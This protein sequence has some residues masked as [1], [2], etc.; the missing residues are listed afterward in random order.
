[1]SRK[2][3]WLF[4]IGI[5]ASLTA[6]DGGNQAE[7]RDWMQTSAKNLRGKIPP[8]PQVSSYTPVNYDAAGLPDPFSAGK[9]EMGRERGGGGLRPDFNRPKE[10]LESY[11]LDS[12]KYVGYLH[13][14]RV[15]YGMV[16]ADGTLFQV[17]VGNYLGQDF[18]I[19]TSI[20]ETEIKLR[21]LVQDSSGDWSERSS[22]IQLQE[23]GEASK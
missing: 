16:L 18:G 17:K 22:S 14:G 6:C 8:L 11:S 20:S 10:P 12:L 9:L 2:L 23:G 21:E 13:H 19:V 15:P 7:L 5:I 3:V 4:V 1:M